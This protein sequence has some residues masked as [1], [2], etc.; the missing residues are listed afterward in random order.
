[1]LIYDDP[2]V[3][4]LVKIDANHAN[5]VRALVMCHKPRRVL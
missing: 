2:A 3:D 5:F 4:D 1:M